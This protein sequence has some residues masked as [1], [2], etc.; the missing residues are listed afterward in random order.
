MKPIQPWATLALLTVL[1]AA[2]ARASGD[3]DHD[4]AAVAPTS[5][6]APQ[7][8]SAASDAFELVGVV[9][10]MHLT[11]YLDRFENNAPVKDAQLAIEIGDAKVALKQVAEGEFEGTLA[12]GLEPGVLAVKASVVA[13]SEASTLTGDLIAPEAEH[14]HD[15]PHRD[16]QPYAAGTA[17]A[18][19]L[20]AGLLWL[21]RRAGAARN[22]RSAA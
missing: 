14:A 6:A 15:A 11:V 5:S 7:R 19:V 2:P 4:H 21:K 16:W 17:A 3:H 13:G 10:G 20:L 1:W 9:S 8:F 22:A 12:A 18:L